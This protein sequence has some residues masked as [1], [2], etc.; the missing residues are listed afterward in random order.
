MTEEKI[1]T[2]IDL[3]E[4]LIP[5]S[6]EVQSFLLE[7]LVACDGS[8]EDANKMLNDTLGVVRHLPV[9]N[10]RKHAIDQDQEDRRRHKVQRSLNYFI[11]DEDK[12]I[13]P[14]AVD[15][16]AKV[17]KNAIELHSKEDIEGNIKYITFHEKILPGD[18]SNDLLRQLLN[19]KEGFTQNEFHLFG[20]KC[21]SSHT[22]KKFTSA[23]FI[24]DGKA[25]LQY[26]NRRGPVYEYNDILKVVQLL[27]EG[28]VNET[29]QKFEPLPFQVRSPNWKGDVVLVNRYEKAEYLLWHSDRLTSLGPQAIVASLSLG[30]AREFRVRRAYP[31]DSQVYII[32][33]PHNSLII[34]H[35]GFQEE[36]KHCIYQ[37]TNNQTTNLHPIS[38]DV[39]FNLTYR[40]YLR[41]Y[42]EDPPRCPRCNAAMDLRRSFKDCRY[43]GQYLWQCAGHYT[44]RDC[45]GMRLAAR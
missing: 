24:L 44:G 29:I 8:L 34:M 2:L 40:N 17:S 26:N 43:R 21:A 3:Y 22:S 33:P 19:D 14:V 4:E 9:G 23:S 25:S 27:V 30:C 31:S 37:Q 35:A 18:L 11:A 41:K 12:K 38:K 36:Y 32:R 5:K 7:V 16:R 13:K 6:T 42:M 28:V 15:T 20:N 39:R 10:N 1:S 45:K